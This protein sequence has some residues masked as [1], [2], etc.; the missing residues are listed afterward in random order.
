MVESGSAVK[1]VIIDAS[2]VLEMDLSAL[3]VIDEL[4]SEMHKQEVEV[5]IAS[6][7][8]RVV[9]SLVSMCVCV[10][11]CDQ[12]ME[13][14]GEAQEEGASAS[15]SSSSSSSISSLIFFQQSL[16]HTHTNTH[17]FLFY[18]KRMISS[19][20]SAA[21]PWSISKWKVCRYTYVC[22]CV[23]VCPSTKKEKD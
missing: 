15:S 2:G 23:C 18:R 8:T 9:K 6:A 17:T 21:F 16:T 20:T 5:F 1:A 4:I 3:A 7:S 12:I 14:R 13:E 19:M 11:V 10:C 22:V